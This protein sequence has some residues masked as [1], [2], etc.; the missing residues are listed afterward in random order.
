MRISGEM[1][2]QAERTA[3]AKVPGWE[4][5]LGFHGEERGITLEA[6]KP[7]RELLWLSRHETEAV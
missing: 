5:Y 4:Y 7:T 6:G 1:A 2:V 3:N